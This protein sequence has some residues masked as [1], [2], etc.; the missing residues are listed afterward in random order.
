MCRREP[1]RSVGN[2]NGRLGGGAYQPADTELPIRV[3]NNTVPFGAI[4]A[5]DA[6]GFVRLRL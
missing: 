4:A 6:G 1:V 2:A 3:I 5:A